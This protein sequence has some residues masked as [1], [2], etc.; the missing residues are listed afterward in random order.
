MTTAAKKVN[1]YQNDNS[2][3]CQTDGYNDYQI[4]S[5]K[6]D[7]VQTCKTKKTV[8]LRTTTLLVKTGSYGS[9][10]RQLQ[11]TNSKSVKMAVVTH[12]KLTTVTAVKLTIL[13]QPVKNDK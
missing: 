5:D 1:I 7:S 2:S 6:N 3:L 12:V 13:Q 10:S 8:K 9:Y 4:A 11:L